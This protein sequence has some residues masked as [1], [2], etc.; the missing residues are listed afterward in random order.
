ALSRGLQLGRQVAGPAA[1]PAGPHPHATSPV[2]SAAPADRA[3][4]RADHARQPD[5]GSPAVPGGR[6]SMK[7]FLI[8][9]LQ[10]LTLALFSWVVT[11]YLIWPLWGG[12]AIFFGVIGAYFGVKLA[13][14]LWLVSRSRVKLAASEAA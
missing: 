12:L 14:R 9:L 13:R 4:G 1:R 2:H 6:Q 8:R 10:L 7:V 5:P 3:G 11:L